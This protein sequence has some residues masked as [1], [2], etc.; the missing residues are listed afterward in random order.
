M[1]FDLESTWQVL[2]SQLKRKCPLVPKMYYLYC[3]QCTTTVTKGLDA[4]Y[5]V[6]SQEDRNRHRWTMNE[7]MISDCTYSSWHTELSCT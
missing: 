1:E 6:G 2:L 3:E 5:N 4:A 7:N